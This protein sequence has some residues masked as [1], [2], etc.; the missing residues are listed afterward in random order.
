MEKR[1]ISDEIKKSYLEYAMSVIVSRALPDIRDG[2][3]PVQ[4]RILYAMSE[5]GFT[6]DKPYKKSARIVGETM[7]KYHPHGDTAIYDT[8]ARMAQDFSLRYPLIDGQGNFGSIDGDAPAA[9][10]YTEARMAP[11]SEEMIQDIDKETVKF[12][13][14]FDGSLEEPEYLPSKIPQLLIN[15]TSGIA[16]GMATNL[17]PHNMT[18]VLDAVKFEIGKPD[19]TVEDLLKYVKAPDFPGGGIVFYTPELL[20]A[21]RTGKG[22][23]L[24]QG[25]VDLKEDRRIIITSLPYGINKSVFISNVAEQAK[26]EILKGITDIRDESDRTGMRIVIKVRDNEMRSLVLN[27]LYEHT[28][29][30]TSIS[31]ANLVLVNNEPKMLDLKSLIDKFIEHRLDIIVKRSEY[32]LKKNKAREHVL[33]GLDVALQN[34]DAVIELIKGSKDTVTARKGLIEKFELTEIQANAILDMRLQRITALETSKIRDELAQV[35]KKIEELEKIIADE[36]VRRKILTREMDEIRK[37]YGDN[38]RTKISYKEVK[39]RSIEDLIPSEESVIILSEGGLLKRVSL[40]EYKA[41]KRG[42][43]GILTSTRKED[44]I[45][46]LVSCDS[47]DV[48][49]FFTNTGRV[50]KSKAYEIPKKSRKAVGTVAEA[51]LSISEGEKVEQI[52]KA[53]EKRGAYLV[54]VTKYGFIKKTP[55]KNL[56]DM[57]ISGLKIITLAEDD[58]VIAVEHSEKPSKVFVLSSNGKAAVFETKEIRATGRTSRGVKSMK[59]KNGETV[60]TSFLVDDS[61][62][63]LSVSEKGIGKRTSLAQFPVH[64]RGS[65]GVFIFKESPKTGKIVKAVPVSD[66]QEIIIVSKKEKTI[67]MSVNGIRLQSRLTSGVRLISMD[68]DDQVITVTVV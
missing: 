65:S 62:S 57:R 8:M 18:E 42:G 20:N 30:E 12:R 60:V 5:M 51:I 19:S 66:D 29:L 40:E 21:Y 55:A 50:L 37:K 38:R 25:E 28:E 10:R 24:C 4:R 17:V 1:P 26:N 7:G 6:H 64:H 61:G 13:L 39:G 11:L 68:E 27:Q 47:H 23:A 16:V 49:Y 52:I 59:L 43:K 48:I 9:M 15:G 63:V 31:I 22:K 32:D 46:G 35:R 53:P 36:A 54:L 44:S 56:F 67:R 58:E 3:K 41:Q 45:K 14:N 34:L 2:L 33:I